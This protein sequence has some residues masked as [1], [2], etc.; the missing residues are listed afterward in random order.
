M[1]EDISNWT[2][3]GLVQR[4]AEAFGEREFMSFEHGTTLTFASLHNDSD[5]LACNLAGLGVAPGDR[6]MVMLKNRIEF[7]LA[8]VAIMK[9]GAIFVPVNTEL[10]G[11]FLQHQMRNAEPRVVFLDTDLVDAFDTVDGGNDSLAAVVYV[12]G[13]VP[14]QRPVVF[15]G[16]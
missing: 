8:M 11:S 6:V 14:D 12:A 3:T 4:Q 9:L 2:L 10:K 1:T 7:L 15:T 16:S 5:Q 13:D